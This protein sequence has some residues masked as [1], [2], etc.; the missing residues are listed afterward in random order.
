MKFSLDYILG[1]IGDA[2]I[3]VDPS[4]NQYNIPLVACQLHYKKKLRT[5]F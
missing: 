3:V 1:H 4:F 5:R 2:E